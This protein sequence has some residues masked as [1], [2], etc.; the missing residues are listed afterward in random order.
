[1]SRT[2]VAVSDETLKRL[3]ARKGAPGTS[4]DEVIADMLDSTDPRVE[5]SASD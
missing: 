1:M 2:T 4:Y 5:V 3:Y